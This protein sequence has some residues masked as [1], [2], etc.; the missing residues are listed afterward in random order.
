MKILLFLLLGIS[1]G[2]TACDAAVQEKN[3]EVTTSLAANRQPGNTD[4]IPSFL[5]CVSLEDANKILGQPSRM[6]NGLLS[7]RPHLTYDCSYRTTGPDPKTNKTGNLYYML[8]QFADS[9]GAKKVYDELI[10]GNRHNSGQSVLSLGTQGHFHTDG[11]NFYFLMVRKGS[12]LLKIKVNKITSLTS[13]Q[14]LKNVA[15]RIVSEM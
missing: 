15:S 6:I 10:E 2:L 13:E 3:I 1:H 12:R 11:E 7:E 9:T 5:R 4:S 8:E 14:E